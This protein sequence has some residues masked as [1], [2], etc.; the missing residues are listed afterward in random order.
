MNYLEYFKEY[1]IKAFEIAERQL[2]GKYDGSRYKTG[3]G[4][5]QLILE[6][7][8]TTAQSVSNL[9]SPTNPL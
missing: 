2:D 5:T 3:H 9:Q 1:E 7:L 8:Q 6:E 4:L